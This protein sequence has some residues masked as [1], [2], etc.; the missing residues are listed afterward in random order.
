MPI[1]IDYRP[2]CDI[3]N[4]TGFMLTVITK[5]GNLIKTKVRRCNKTGFHTLIGIRCADALGWYPR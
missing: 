5:T 3:P 2:L 4:Q 1:P